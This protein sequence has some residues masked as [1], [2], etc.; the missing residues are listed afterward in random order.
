VPVESPQNT[1]EENKAQNDRHLVWARLLLALVFF[2]AT[3]LVFY[4]TGLV[5]FLAD[6]DRMAGFISFL[7]VWGAL[8]FVLLSA[9]QVVVAPI[10]AE[11]TGF[12]GG[13]IYGP[14]LGAF[15][16]TVGL[17]L[18]SAAVFCL[19]RKLGAPFVAWVAGREALKK[20][21][22]L[23]KRKFKIMV[24]LFF[25]L[26]GMPKDIACYVLGLGSYTIG[27]F[28]LLTAT[29]R[30]FSTVLFTSFGVLVKDGN[31]LASAIVGGVVALLAIL[32]FIYRNEI[33]A[34][35][36]RR[37]GKSPVPGRTIA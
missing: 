26:P 32:G 8:G 7:G 34:L 18:G 17:I 25:L 19:S 24:F 22:Y 4:K 11:I 27:E 21:R 13:Y 15:L 5:S 3:S 30:V 6:K 10:P 35:L 29:G 12:L 9:A 16:S 20:F 1:P 23:S 28:L 31:Y 2:G 33:E 14:F 37:F 36:R